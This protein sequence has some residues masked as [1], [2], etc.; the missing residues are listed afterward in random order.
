[1]ACKLLF[2]EVDADVL[3]LLLG[4]DRFPTIVVVEDDS[5]AL[6]VDDDFPTSLLLLLEDLKDNG[7]GPPTS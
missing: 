1:M 5:E 7:P 3:L 2:R 6:V 4:F